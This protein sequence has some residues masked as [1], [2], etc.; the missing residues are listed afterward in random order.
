VVELGKKI[1]SYLITALNSST[2]SLIEGGE[3][4]SVEFKSTLRY[5][6][7]TKKFDKEIEHAALKTIAAFLNS[8]G[9]TLLIGVD[10]KKTF[11]SLDADNFRN[12]D[13]MLLHLAK[14]IEE[15]LGMIQTQFV[16]A[17]IDSADNNKVLRIDVKPST[18]PAYLTYK[19]DEIFYI[20][21]GP[22][23]AQLKISELFHYL[24]TRFYSHLK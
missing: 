2:Q 15:N 12:D 9:G 8:A 4:D 22:S 23:T 6:L 14:L 16:N 13:H 1:T 3:N 19:N 5:N 24:N 10:D 20:R 17:M 18:A 11:L 21:S 7:F